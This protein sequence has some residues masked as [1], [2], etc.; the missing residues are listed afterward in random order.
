MGVPM[1][2]LNNS[3]KLDNQLDRGV[4]L[5]NTLTTK[6]DDQYAGAKCSGEG[7]RSGFLPFWQSLQSLAR[8]SRQMASTFA[9]HTWPPTDGLSPSNFTKPSTLPPFHREG[10]HHGPPAR[11]GWL[12]LGQLGLMDG[13][14]AARCSKG[15][16][17]CTEA[18][19]PMSGA[20]WGTRI[21]LA[22]NLACLQLEGGEYP[23]L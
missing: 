6:W 12:S 19:S 10:L 16:P 11:V 1:F 9:F 8:G 4:S 13:I 14:V 5:R 22:S 23:K 15:P 3:N 17:P 18:L 20:L 2:Q 7:L 21:F